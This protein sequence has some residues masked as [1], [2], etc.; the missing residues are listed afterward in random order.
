MSIK[1]QIHCGSQSNQYCRQCKRVSCAFQATHY[2]L[3]PSPVSFWIAF[4]SVI[5]DLLKI[6]NWSYQNY[7][8]YGLSGITSVFITDKKKTQSS[9]KDCRV[10]IYNSSQPET[11]IF[12]GVLVAL[13]GTQ[14][15]PAQKGLSSPYLTSL[16]QII[17]PVHSACHGYS[18]DRERSK[19]RQE[20][21]CR[22]IKVHKT[23]SLIWLWNSVQT[24]RSKKKKIR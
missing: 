14:K 15:I 23:S 10:Y 7:L 18:H 21:S 19:H 12:L 4:I 11:H 13:G 8:L 2:F 9:Q 1:E 16:V 6:K 5:S 3:L 17:H 24:W 22:G 20:E